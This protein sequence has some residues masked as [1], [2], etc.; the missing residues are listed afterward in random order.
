MSWL[1]E[2]Y[3]DIKGNL[4]FWILTAAISSGS[5]GSFLYAFRQQVMGLPVDAYIFAGLCIVSVSLFGFA[6]SQMYK[7]ALAM[8]LVAGRNEIV[9]TDAAAD[10]GVFPTN[11]LSV[12]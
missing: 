12:C 5:A 6:A 8:Q 3:D 1:R 4:K 2:Q 11:G 7:A 9:T 10:I